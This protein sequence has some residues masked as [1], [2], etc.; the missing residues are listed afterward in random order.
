MHWKAPKNALTDVCVYVM[1][2]LPGEAM[3]RTHSGFKT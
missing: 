1:L 2:L 3:E